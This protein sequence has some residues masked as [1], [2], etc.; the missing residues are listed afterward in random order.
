ML[1]KRLIGA[2]TVK[3][4]WAVQSFGYRRYLPIGRPE[5][6]AENLDRWGADEIL[7][8][9]ID[10]SSQGLEPDFETLERVARR[11]LSTPTILAGGIRTLAHGIRAISSGADRIAI[12]AV[13]RDDPGA[14]R[15]LSDHLGAQAV[16]AALPVTRDGDRV[17]WHDYRARMDTPF[18]D[19]VSALIAEKVV[20][21]VAVIDWR[22]EGAGPF[23]LGLIR[24]FPFADVPLIAFGGLNDAVQQR[25]V[26]EDPRVVAAMVGNV[27]NYREH[28]IAAL[29]S[30]LSGVPI[31]VAHQTE[32]VR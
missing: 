15:A 26:L 3:N 25:A 22:H 30:Q 24:A 8:Q 11:G 4:G 21:E 32:N 28:A 16:I 20:S 27:L 31:R 14:V 12:D 9:C 17:R 29:K 19:A 10:R 5:V 2:I 6:V 7:V 1:K 18:S 13:L 23:D